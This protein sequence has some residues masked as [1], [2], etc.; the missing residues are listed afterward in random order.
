LATELKRIREEQ[1]T[2]GTPTNDQL[3]QKL[4]LAL[5]PEMLAGF[6]AAITGTAETEVFKDNV[7]PLNKLD[8][9]LLSGEP[10]IR[11]SYSEVLERQRLTSRGLLLDARKK[12]LKGN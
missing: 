8:P 3:R 11:L 2:S 9:K 5:T 4:A 7:E 6:I 1:A 10:G 12:A